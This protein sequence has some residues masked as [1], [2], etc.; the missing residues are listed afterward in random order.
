MRQWAI[1]GTVIDVDGRLYFVY[2]GWPEGEMDNDLVQRLFIIR[3]SDPVTA[4]SR[5][6]EICKPEER[7]E[8]TDD[9]GINEGECVS[10][11]PCSG[12]AERLS[13]TTVA[14]QSGWQLARDRVLVRWLLDQGLQDEYAPFAAKC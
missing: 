5:A 10:C 13:R 9:H 11:R 3:L 14:S 8:W 2:S 7:W 1:D 12:D 4:D 6:V